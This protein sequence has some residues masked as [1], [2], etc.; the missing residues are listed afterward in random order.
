MTKG[1]QE[2]LEGLRPC[3]INKIQNKKINEY[4]EL[5]KEANKHPP[6]K[7]YI[8]DFICILIANGDVKKEADQFIKE[9]MDEYNHKMF[10]QVALHT[11]YVL[12]S[13]SVYIAYILIFLSER[14][15]ELIDKSYISNVPVFIAAIVL[16]LVTLISN[17][18][19]II[20]IHSK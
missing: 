8:N 2:L 12:V 14:G 10:V 1:F 19:S 18:V 3:I 4:V 15:Y 13:V 7:E 11:T 5:Y 20:R 6:N 17:T 16:L 9:V